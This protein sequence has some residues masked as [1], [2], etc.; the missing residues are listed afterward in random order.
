MRIIGILAAV[1]LSLSVAA[2]GDAKPTAQGAAGPAGPAGPPGPKGDVG[3]SGPTGS[4]GPS[5]PQGPAGPAGPQGAQGP[6]GSTASA[7]A[8]RV[9]RANCDAGDCSIT[10]NAD[11]LVLNAYCGA[12]RAPASFPTDQRATCRTRGTRTAFLIA[13]CAQVT[14]VPTAAP[15]ASKPQPS[16]ESSGAV[17]RF[18]IA[19]TCRD[20]AGGMGATPSTCVS[21]EQGARDELAKGWS[22]YPAADRARC[23]QLAGMTAGLQSYVQ[24]LTCLDMAAQAKVLESR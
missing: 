23:S 1:A 20:V 2:C 21:D 4:A 24:L 22:R 12:A 14:A 17:P 15:D 11:E 5:G 18:D 10:C 7:S 9:L 16:R 19:A 6:A 3:P 13:A 8:V